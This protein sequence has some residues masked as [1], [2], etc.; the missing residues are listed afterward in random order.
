MDN[1]FAD[2]QITEC[3]RTSLVSPFR[4]ALSFSTTSRYLEYFKRFRSIF[5]SSPSLP[6]YYLPGNH[7]VGLG[8]GSNTSRF[9]RSRYRAAFGPLSQHVA[10]GGH[11]L[12][13]VDAPSLV[14]EDWRREQAGESR[15]DGL[16]Q[17][18]NFVKHST[19]LVRVLSHFPP[20]GRY[21]FIFLRPD[22]PLILFSHIPLY[23]SPDSSDD[24]LRE[25]G[26]IP[27]VRGDGY[28]TQLSLETSQL[29]LK[30]FRPSLV[31]RYF[32]FRLFVRTSSLVDVKPE[33]R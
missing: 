5:S 22:A 26:L 15:I 30:E 18:L 16:P 1:G 28:Q 31:F 9:A 4:P 6:V 23:R 21:L 13:M 12:V 19:E 25:R 8:N 32:F 27:D 2:M 20:M 10:L 24:S 11:S 29:L 7:D 33:Q 3:A 14:D 17:D